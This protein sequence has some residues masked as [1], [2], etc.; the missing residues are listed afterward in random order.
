MILFFLDPEQLYQT[1]G[2]LCYHADTLLQLADIYRHQEGSSTLCLF[3]YLS[4]NMRCTIEHSR[5]ADTLSRALFAYER[6]FVGTSLSNF[7]TGEARLDFDRVEN[8]VFY[9][10][11]GRTIVYAFRLAVVTHLYEKLTLYSYFILCIYAHFIVTY[12]VVALSDP[13]S[14]SLVYC[15]RWIHTQ[16]H[17]DLYSTLTI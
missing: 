10:A 8:R 3:T 4:F 1:L 5:N 6:A 2:K 14:N 13:H 11:V 15:Y 17:T 12:I 7:A 9:L 16:I